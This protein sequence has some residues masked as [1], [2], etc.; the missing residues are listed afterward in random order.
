MTKITR[1]IVTISSWWFND[2]FCLRNKTAV[3]SSFPRSPSP[4][5]SWAKSI[6]WLQAMNECVWCTF[7]IYLQQRKVSSPIRHDCNASLGPF[8]TFLR[9][10]SERDRQRFE[11]FRMSRLLWIACSPRLVG[12]W[13]RNIVFLLN[14]IGFY[15]KSNFTR[16]DF[17]VRCWVSVS[18]PKRFERGRKLLW[19]PSRSEQF[20]TSSI[21][22]PSIYESSTNFKELVKRWTWFGSKETHL[23]FTEFFSVIQDGRFLATTF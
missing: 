20:S 11:S 15:C 10:P 9:L 7:I 18:C 22:F 6:R 3:L 14:M 2:S 1:G 17:P 13:I 19:F 23:N 4:T 21:A 5:R 16:R 12:I 8:S